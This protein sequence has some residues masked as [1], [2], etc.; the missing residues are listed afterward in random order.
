MTTLSEI[1]DTVQSNWP[2][3]YFSTYLTDDKVDEY[4]NKVQKW[5]CRGTIIIPDYRMLNYNF[6]W[7]KTEVQSSTINLQRRYALPAGGTDPLRFKSELSCEL[8]TSKSQR[9]PLQRRLKNDIENDSGYLDTTDSGTPKCYAI[10]DF[11][12]WLYPLPNHSNNSNAAWTINLEYYGYLKDLSG[13]TDENIL[14]NNYE[15]ILEFGATE[16]GYR[17]GKDFEQAEYWKNLKE[18]LYVEIILEDQQLEYTGL[19]DGIQPL[20]GNNLGEGEA[21]LGSYY[22]NGTSYE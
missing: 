13:D 18:K 10:D 3:G 21:G 1:R 16:M 5:V 9:I 8:I 14:T 11:D 7:L 4:I 6:S 19:E 20:E 2:S 12:L 17:Y 15:E 22:D